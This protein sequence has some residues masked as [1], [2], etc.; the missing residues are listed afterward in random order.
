MKKTKKKIV[1]LEIDSRYPF[2][3]HTNKQICSG[4]TKVDKVLTFVHIRRGSR[5][6]IHRSRTLEQVS[7]SRKV[8]VCHHKTVDA[9]PCDEP[10]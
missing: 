8:F 9:G 10:A 7:H 2:R 1:V 3:G 6:F 5:N 4:R